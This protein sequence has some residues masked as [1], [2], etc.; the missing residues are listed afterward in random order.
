MHLARLELGNQ[1]IIVH[2]SDGAACKL[3]R[4]PALRYPL[5]CARVHCARPALSGD[6][7]APV[8]ASHQP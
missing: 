7:I 2:W 8:Q 5:Q 3:L 6:T 1:N 4:L